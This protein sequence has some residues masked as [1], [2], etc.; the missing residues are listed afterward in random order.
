MTRRPRCRA[1]DGPMTSAILEGTKAPAPVLPRLSG[2]C[3]H[4]CDLEP[5]KDKGGGSGQGRP[6]LRGG[7]RALHLASRGAR[8]WAV[9]G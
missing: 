8:S 5:G 2:P 6:R 3:N 4:A 9:Q 1:Q 7:A